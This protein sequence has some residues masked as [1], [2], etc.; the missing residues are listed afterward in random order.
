MGLPEDT[1]ERE[2]VI[3]QRWHYGGSGHR[4]GELF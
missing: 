4:H 2:K 3:V 1:E